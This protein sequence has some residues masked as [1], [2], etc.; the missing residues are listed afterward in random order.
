[1]L[2]KY[3]SILTKKEIDYLI[4]AKFASSFIVYKGYINPR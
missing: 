2:K 3:E 4:N 1:M